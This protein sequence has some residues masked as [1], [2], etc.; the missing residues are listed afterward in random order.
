M[1]E[2][3][4]RRNTV[5]PARVAVRRR[6][7]RECQPVRSKSWTRRGEDFQIGSQKEEE[8]DAAN[9]I[10]Y[11]KRSSS[12]DAGFCSRISLSGRLVEND[13]RNTV[14]SYDAATC[15]L[16]RGR[17]DLTRAEYFPTRDDTSD[18]ISYECR[19]GWG[20]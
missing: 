20:T 15:G 16:D 12:Q 1:F 10:L 19:P 7:W 9:L 18:L 11:L 3:R 2:D 8:R 4:Q 5:K 14:F 13:A 6:I 17:V